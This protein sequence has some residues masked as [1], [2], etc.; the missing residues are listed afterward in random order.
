VAC[1]NSRLV[2]DDDVVVDVVFFYQ[3]LALVFDF[4]VLAQVE[5]NEQVARNGK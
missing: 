1:D 2:D 4:V 5:S 3:S